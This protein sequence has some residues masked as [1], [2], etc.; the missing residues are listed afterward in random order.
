MYQA[1]QSNAL[2]N[3]Q[4]GNINYNNAAQLGMTVPQAQQYYENLQ[5][6]NQAAQ[7]AQQQALEREVAQQQWKNE[8]DYNNYLLNAQKVANDTAQ[9]NYNVN[10]PYNSTVY[11]VSNNNGNEGKTNYISYKDAVNL[12]TNSQ[13]PQATADAMIDNGLINEETWRVLY[14]AN[15]EWKI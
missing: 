8:M 9:T 13:N 6:Q 12:I 2:N 14:A 3:I 1:G 7:L 15:P 5:A 11:H 4:A 10:K